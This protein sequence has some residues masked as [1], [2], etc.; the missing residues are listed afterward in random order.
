M[1][2]YVGG[3]SDDMTEVDV[4]AV[5]S[6]VCPPQSVTII[7]DIDSGKSRGFAIVK[8]PSEEKGECT[9]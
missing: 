4:E 2:L 8:I 6:G 3:L 5:F 9:T 1:Q 7:R